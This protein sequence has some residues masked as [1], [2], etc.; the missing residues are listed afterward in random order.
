MIRHDPQF[1]EKV[2]IG[3]L[4]SSARILAGFVDAVEHRSWVLLTERAQSLSSTSVPCLNSVQMD[5]LEAWR[6]DPE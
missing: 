2:E 1:S 5:R 4:E 6:I 3:R